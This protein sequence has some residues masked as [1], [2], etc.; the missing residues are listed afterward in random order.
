[1]A[2]EEVTIARAGRPVVKLVRASS[3]P[4]RRTPGG[5]RGKVTVAPDF[6]APLP[7]EIG[8]AFE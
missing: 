1:M 6:D 3:E 4:V 8:R 2:G 5:A 7:D